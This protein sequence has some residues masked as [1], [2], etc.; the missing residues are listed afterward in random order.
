VTAVAVILADGGAD[1]GPLWLR[2]SIAL[3]PPTFAAIVAGYFG[4]RN[5]V[6]RR[7]DRLKNLND[8]RVSSDVNWV[9]PGYA[10]ERIML[11]ELKSLDR[12]TSASIK[13]L[14]RFLILVFVCSCGIYVYIGGLKL[15]FIHKTPTELLFI[16]AATITTGVGAI[17]MAAITVLP[18]KINF[19][20]KPREIINER[21]GQGIAA[22]DERGAQADQSSS[23]NEPL[24][25]PE[26]ASSTK[27][28]ARQPIQPIQRVGSD[29]VSRLSQVVTGVW[30]SMMVVRLIAAASRTLAK[31]QRG[32]L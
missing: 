32:R 22:L 4:L 13:W 30:L 29:F 6:S 12:A 15:G 16:E 25:S 5:T 21:Y 10:L 19:F 11:Q 2:I 18:D 23:G 26:S 31:G 1:A 14:R 27:S 8:I 24:I 20:F 17:I 7:I 3:G 9:N 28:T